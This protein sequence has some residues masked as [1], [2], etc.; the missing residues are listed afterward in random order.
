MHC[1]AGN[2]C[3][4]NITTP[5]NGHAPSSP[6]GCCYTG[7]SSTDTT[8]QSHLFTTCWN[9]NDEPFGPFPLPQQTGY[10]SYK[11]KDELFWYVY[12]LMVVIMLTRMK[13]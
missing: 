7:G 1:G 4:K 13:H 11:R 9:Y 10:T 12:G 6:F 2:V 8:A 3:T 5:S